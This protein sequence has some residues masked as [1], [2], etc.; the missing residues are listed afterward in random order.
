MAHVQLQREKKK[1]C[2]SYEICTLTEHT[3]TPTINT[4]VIQQ[5]I[6]HE[7]NAHFIHQ[8]I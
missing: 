3:I 7:A 4:A 6:S 5:A 8:S 2:K 1:V